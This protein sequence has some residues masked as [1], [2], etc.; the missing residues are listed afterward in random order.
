MYCRTFRIMD[1]DRSNSLNMD[2]FKKGIHDYGVDMPKEEV[3]SMFNTIDKDGS[4]LIDFDEFLIA[5]RV[6]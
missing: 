1:D 5:L 3:Q 6:S 4:G 2:E